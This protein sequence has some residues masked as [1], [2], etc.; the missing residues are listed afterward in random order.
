MKKETELITLPYL[1]AG[2][3]NPGRKYSGN[4]HNVG[5][6][7][8]DT[9]AK[10]LTIKMKRIKHKAVIGTGKLEDKQLLLV[11]PQT[12][13]NASGQSISPLMRYYKVPLEHLKYGFFL[14]D[15]SQDKSCPIKAFGQIFQRALD[16]HA[17]LP[18]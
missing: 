15:L 2:L 8:I 17:Q 7:V 18:L 5:F 1:I 6:M 4:R 3:G 10:E 13:M 11:K 16:R 12:Y 14:N 9:L